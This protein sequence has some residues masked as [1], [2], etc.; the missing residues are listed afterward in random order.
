[1]GHHPTPVTVP[2][3]NRKYAMRER[4]REKAASAYQS[5]IDR[6]IAFNRF[7]HVG[8]GVSIPTGPKRKLAYQSQIDRAIAFNRFVHVG[9]AFT[10]D[11]TESPV[12]DVLQLNVLHTDRLMIQLVGYSR[13][14]SIFS[15]RKLLTSLLKTLRQS[16]TGFSLLGLSKS[17]QHHKFLHWNLAFTG[18]STESPVYDVLQLN[19]LH[20]DRLM[21]QLVGY[22]RY[23]SIFSQRK[24]LTSLLKTLRQS[25]TGFSLLGLSKSFQQL[26]VLHQAASC[27]SRYDIRDI[28]IYVYVCNVLLIRLLKFLGTVNLGGGARWPKWLERGFTDRK[29]RGSNPIS[30]SRLPL[31]RLGPLGTI[32][33]ISQYIFIKETTH[34]VAENSSTAHDRFRPSW[35]SSVSFLYE[36][37]LRYLEYRAKWPVCSTFS[38]RI[39]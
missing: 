14:R 28:A 18:D 23:R 36:N 22:S 5:Q 37:I 29:A 11:S 17:L 35:G 4:E 7:V 12:Y 31:F 38:R 27:F 34:K 16:T 9:P 20:T 32:F 19:V 24:L 13:Y 3:N 39:S 8:P 15:Q 25:T 21:I 6:A 10:G 1:M 33:E 2:S 30:A 26:N